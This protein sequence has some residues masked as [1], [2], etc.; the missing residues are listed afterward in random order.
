VQSPLVGRAGQRRVNPGHGVDSGLDDVPAAGV[1]D[2]PAGPV[3]G[4]DVPWVGAAGA[5]MAGDGR[6]AGLDPNCGLGAGR[7]G[8]A[9][10]GANTGAFAGAAGFATGLAFLAAV[11]F[12]AAFFATTFFAT[13]FFA[14]VLR[15]ADLARAPAFFLAEPSF[16][17]L[18]PIL[19]ALDFLAVDLR[20]VTLRAGFFALVALDALL[21][22]GF[23][24]LEADFAISVHSLSCHGD[25]GTDTFVRI[26]TLMNRVGEEVKMHDE[27]HPAHPRG[28]WDPALG[29]TGAWRRHPIPIEVPPPAFRAS[30]RRYDGD[31]NGI[32]LI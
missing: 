8:A 21:L 13:T 12:G 24:F 6:G 3:P 25:H 28:E 15:F 11:F 5:G 9:G 29:T 18:A 19:R 31:K 30:R 7:G 16:A 32:V 20:A 10:A 1:D 26:L 14:T 22:A 17:F 2:P 4:V 27:A 23:F